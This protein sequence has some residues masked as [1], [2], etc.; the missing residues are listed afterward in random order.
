MKKLKYLVIH[1]SDTPEGRRVMASDVVD[2]HTKEPP[3]GFGW[4]RAGYSDIV[5]LDGRVVNVRDYDGDNWV[6][7]D[8]VTYGARG[9]NAES[10][11]VCYI[12]G[13]D[14]YGKVRDTRTPEQMRAL[15][16]YCIKMK[17][18]HPDI[19]IVGHHDL[20]PGKACPSF[21][22]KKWFEKEWNAYQ[23]EISKGIVRQLY[24]EEAR[25]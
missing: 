17:L 16:N 13:R 21:D 14:R 7:R 24:Y 9:Y 23:D 12:G 18:G 15:R 22:V 2:W 5:E 20:N 6:Q 10:R 25:I 11:H 8:E 19:Q 3:V 4:S 1:C